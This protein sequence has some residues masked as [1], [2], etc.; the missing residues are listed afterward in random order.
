MGRKNLLTSDFFLLPIS[1]FL[2]STKGRRFL[3]GG[4]L[5]AG[6]LFGT[7]SK[8]FG[9]NLR[10]VYSE[11]SENPASRI[12]ALRMPFAPTSSP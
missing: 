7:A 12:R 9:G 1:Y 11:T 5:T 6:K 2:L 4:S 3:F 8:L 10:K